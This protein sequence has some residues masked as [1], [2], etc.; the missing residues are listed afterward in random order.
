MSADAA[1][2]CRGVTCCS[3]C[4]GAEEREAAAEAV[5]A[6]PD[7]KSSVKKSGWTQSGLT[8]AIEPG[9]YRTAEFQHCR[10]EV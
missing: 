3:N 8:N 10:D 1:A 4:H 9:R 2:L 5:A 6:A 7:R